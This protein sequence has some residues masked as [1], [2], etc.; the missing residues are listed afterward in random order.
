MPHETVKKSV[1]DV[2]ETVSGSVAAALDYTKQEAAAAAERATAAL[3]SEAQARAEAGKEM[4]SDQGRKLADRLRADDGADDLQSRI[5]NV[6]AGGV[7]ELSDDLRRR[8]LASL[9]DEAE[10]FARSH[11]GAFVAG[12]AVAGFVLSRFARASQTEASDARTALAPLPGQWPAAPA[13][14]PAAHHAGPHLGS[15]S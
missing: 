1:E 5:L 2:A 4:V 13:T 6:V 12:A 9:V 3:R 10:R 11:P 8:S 14:T 15:K 7:S